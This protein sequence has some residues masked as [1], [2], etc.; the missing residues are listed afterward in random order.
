[1]ALHYRLA[2]LDDL[3]GLVALLAADP[4]GSQREDVSMPLNESYIEA[5]K[6]IEADPNNLLLIAELDGRLAG[7]LQL[8]FTPYLTH[9]GGWRASIEGVRIH[10]AF[11]GQ[12]YGE[13]MFAHAIAL[14]KEKGCHVLQLASD[15]QRPDAI[16]FYEKIGFK[17][18]HEG[19]KLVL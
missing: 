11:R 3:E 9:Q 16:R 17:A 14:A 15:K 12:G 6:A 10:E 13:K 5:F 2:S 1:M 8:T 7:M 4:L 19:F 18:T